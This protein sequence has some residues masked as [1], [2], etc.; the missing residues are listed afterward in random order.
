MVTTYE[1]GY[2]AR[3]RPVLL[4]GQEKSNTFRIVPVHHKADG[5]TETGMATISHDK[6]PAIT[7]KRNAA[8]LKDAFK[9]FAEALQ[10]GH[11]YRLIAPVNSYSLASGEAATLMVQAFKVLDAGMRKNVIIELFDFTPN[12]NLPILEDAIVPVFPFF[13]HIT[14][15]PNQDMDDF[16]VFANCN[17][18]AVC[19]N[20][21]IVDQSVDGAAEP[22]KKFWASATKRRLKIFFENIESAEALDTA[23]RYEALGVDGP[24]ISEDIET[25]M[26]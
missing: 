21:G 26:A 15:R 8:V 18:M 16:T 13:D 2:S 19:M 1:V 9:D 5:T 23:K 7:A 17:L 12:L 20:L 14:A 3:F 11:Q 22:M 10:S 6:D 25:L 24:L 4:L